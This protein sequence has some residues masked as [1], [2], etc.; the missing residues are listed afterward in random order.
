MSK[1]ALVGAAVGKVTAADPAVAGFISQ[2]SRSLPVRRVYFSDT[3]PT[4]LASSIISGDLGVRRIS[5]DFKPVSSTTTQLNTFLSDC[6]ANGLDFDVSIW[7]EMFGDFSSGANF[8]SAMTPYM[9]VVQQYTR[10]IWNPTNFSFI[11]NNLVANGWYPGD[12]LVD[13]I[14]S[15]F[16]CQGSAPGAGGDT[17]D[18][19]ANFA[20]AHSKPFGI[21][22]FNADAANGNILTEAQ[23]DAFLDYMLSFFGARLNASKPC[24]DLLYFNSGS[25]TLQ[26]GPASWTTIY[27]ELFDAFSG[28]P[29]TTANQG[30]MAAFFC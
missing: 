6:Q 15:D 26:N 30:A 18:A 13:V 8:V 4:S 14:S 19:M 29:A 2:T 12:S 28:A 9:Q 10:H 3:I 17:L 22:E 25:N 23:G 5:M 16:Y 24:A 1:P 7:H 11:H 20:D 21:C 27:Q